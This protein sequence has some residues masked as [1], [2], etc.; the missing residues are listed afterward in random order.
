MI[1]F[2][3]SK[4]SAD[5]LLSAHKSQTSGWLFCKAIGDLKHIRRSMPKQSFKTARKLPDRGLRTAVKL[6]IMFDEAIAFPGC[7]S[8]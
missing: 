2:L 5:D 8:G 1:D 3:R 7:F 6:S 4:E